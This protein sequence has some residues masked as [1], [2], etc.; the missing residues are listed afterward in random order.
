M[1]VWKEEKEEKRSKVRTIISPGGTTPINTRRLDAIYASRG[2]HSRLYLSFDVHEGTCHQSI[3]LIGVWRSGPVSCSMIVYHTNPYLIP[4]CA[5]LFKF[6]CTHNRSSPN[7]ARSSAKYCHVSLISPYP[8][9]STNPQTP[10]I[11]S[12]QIHIPKSSN[13][14]LHGAFPAEQH[15]LIYNVALDCLNG[16]Q[17]PDRS[18]NEVSHFSLLSGLRSRKYSHQAST[19]HLQLLDG[20]LSTTLIITRDIATI[21]RSSMKSLCWRFIPKHFSY[22]FGDFHVRAGGIW[23]ED[24]NQAEVRRRSAT[25][26]VRGF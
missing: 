9:V 23:M 15:T 1:C 18:F 3:W 11:P 19:A 6:P 22:A 25:W 10:F 13:P 2:L 24:D 17:P 12:L 21:P 14:T 16:P 5:C 8:F 4:P 20:G 7:S 26:I